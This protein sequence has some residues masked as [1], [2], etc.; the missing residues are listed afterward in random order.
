MIFN[1]RFERSYTVITLTSCKGGTGK[2]TISANLSAALSG[3]GRTVLCIDCVKDVAVI[4]GGAAGMTAAIFAA[5]AGASVTLYEKNGTG[6][7]GRKLGITGKGRCNLTNECGIDDFLQNIAS[8]P[9]FLY[10]AFASFP[11]RE[12]MSW[13]ESLGVPLK[14]ER[15]RR[16][17]P[18][19]DKATDVVFALTRELKRSGAGLR[20]SAV[21]S[22]EPC[23][24]GF[25]IIT[26]A[27]E[28]LFRSVIIATGGKSYSVTGSDGSGYRLAGS[29]GHTLTPPVPALV[30]LVAG[31]GICARLQGLTLKNIAFTVR[32]IS[33]GRAVYEDFGELLF[34]HFGL[35]GPVVLSASSVIN[36]EIAPGVFR[37]EIDLK[38]A[39]EP[40][41]LDA[42]LLSDFSSSLN[43][44][45]SNSIS[46][47][48]PSKLI[49]V[50]VERTGIAPDR[51]VNSITK[52]ERAPMMRPRNPRLADTPP[53]NAANIEGRKA[54]EDPRK[55][56]DPDVVGIFDLLKLSDLFVIIGYRVFNGVLVLEGRGVDVD[57]RGGF[58]ID[59]CQQSQVAPEA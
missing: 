52:A 24:E 57:R 56:G 7:L 39:L 2:S 17:F 59:A 42:R 37:A 9:R 44:N 22:V 28:S 40:A 25:R 26:G 33:D 3:K 30:P 48:L 54:N 51:K 6:R 45:F 58:G 27:G 18:V 36:R 5:R 47:L 14:T 20:G 19:S 8:N 43:R 32:R 23:A 11:P 41:V 21:L 16:V 31:G 15:G 53:A 29:L 46:A 55:T 10:S 12:V 1:Q 38:P 35:T 4:G 34:A 13:F 49:P 50:F